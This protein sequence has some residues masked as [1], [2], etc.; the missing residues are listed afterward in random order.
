MNS[1][2][3]IL[4]SIATFGIQGGFPRRVFPQVAPMLGISLLRESQGASCCRSRNWGGVALEMMKEVGGEAG[5]GA[6]F[7]HKKN[8]VCGFIAMRFDP[9][10]VM[11]THA[12][13]MFS[14]VLN[15]ADHLFMYLSH[16]PR[17]IV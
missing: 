1:S 11:R 4:G 12:R 5:G 8:L 15:A 10:P 13:Q 3:V 16:T 7:F 14:T 9:V 17:T 6:Y 2:R